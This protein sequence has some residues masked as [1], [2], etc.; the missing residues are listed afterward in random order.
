MQ[1]ICQKTNS[2]EEWLLPGPASGLTA[3]LLGRWEGR[4]TLARKP[5]YVYEMLAHVEMKYSR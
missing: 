1:V 2:V 5:S 4:E 3:K